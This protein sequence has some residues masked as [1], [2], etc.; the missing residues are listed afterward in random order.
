MFYEKKYNK[1]K[2]IKNLNIYS[3]CLVIAKIT[4]NNVV[5]TTIQPKKVVTSKGIHLIDKFPSIIPKATASATIIP[6][7]QTRNPRSL[8]TPVFFFAI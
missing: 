7:N 5:I 6:V 8:P 2:E 3:N 4:P 1:K